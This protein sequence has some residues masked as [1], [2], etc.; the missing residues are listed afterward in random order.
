MLP[1]GKF[2]AALIALPGGIL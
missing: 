2:K 1:V